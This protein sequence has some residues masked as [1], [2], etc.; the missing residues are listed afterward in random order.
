MNTD[1]VVRSVR[2]ARHDLVTY[3]VV[4][5][6]GLVRHVTVKFAQSVPC[7]ADPIIRNVIRETQPTRVVYR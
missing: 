1:Y 7:E 4:D 5:T 3:T 6:A 2:R